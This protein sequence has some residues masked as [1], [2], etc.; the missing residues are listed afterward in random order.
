MR[1]SLGNPDEARGRESPRDT[2]VEPIEVELKENLA[3]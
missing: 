2:P 3:R 1:R